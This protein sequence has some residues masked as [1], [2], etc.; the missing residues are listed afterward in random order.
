MSSQGL[1]ET[2][3][4]P[5]RQ[6]DRESATSAAQNCVSALPQP[7]S[8]VSG[9]DACLLRLSSGRSGAS[10]QATLVQ[11]ACQASAVRAEFFVAQRDLCSLRTTR[12]AGLD[13]PL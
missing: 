12:G 8:C 11:E 9:G 7:S 13:Q 3:H 10:L 1:L 2:A 6:L 5:G 4:P